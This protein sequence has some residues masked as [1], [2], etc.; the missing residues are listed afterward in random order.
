MTQANSQAAPKPKRRAISKKT[1]F[2]VFKRDGFKCQYCGA[3]SP[4]A[5]LVVDHIDPVSKNGAHD[6]MNFI[7]ACQPC[8]SGKSDRTLS[9]STAIEK[10]RAQLDELK[11]RREQLEMMLKWRDGLQEIAAD[12]LSHVMEAWADAAPGWHLNDT[13][14]KTATKYLKKHGLQAVLDAIDTTKLQYIR[15][16]DGKADATT[17][18][19]AWDKV[20]GILRL[21][22][23][24]DEERRLY[25]VK[26]ILRNRLS[27]MPH[28]VMRHLESALRDGVDVDEMQQEAK[29]ARTWTKYLDWLI[30]AREQLR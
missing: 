29:H 13:G 12:E 15:I 20:G 14:Q 5:V 11:E 24:P 7:T 3:A 16:I 26:G 28:D 10:Q 9:D 27:W 18:S 25:Y 2:E 19:V 8:N 4:E 17:V 21:A 30:D 6:M 22:G 23:M 1:R